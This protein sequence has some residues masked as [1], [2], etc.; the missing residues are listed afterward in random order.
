MSVEPS[1]WEYIIGLSRT[2]C[3]LYSV[4]PY[5][6]ES[7]SGFYVEDLV[8]LHKWASVLNCEKGTDLLDYMDKSRNE[9]IRQF[10]TN[11]NALLMRYNRLKRRPYR[12]KIGRR[13]YTDYLTNLTTGKYYGVRLFCHDIVGGILRLKKVGGMFSTTGTIQV[14]IYNN[15]NEALYT[16]DINTIAGAYV[17]TDLTSLDIELPLHSEYVGN[18]EYYIYYEKGAANPRNNKWFDE[19]KG[20]YSENSTAYSSQTK[21]QFGWGQY[22]KVNGLALSDVSDLSDVVGSSNRYMY[23]LILDVEALCKIGDLWCDD[24]VGFDYEGDNLALAIAEAVRWKAASILINDI[25][26]SNNLNRSVMIDGETL[27]ERMDRWERSYNEALDFIVANIDITK[28]DC[29]ECKDSIEI[30]VGGIKY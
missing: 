13:K 26:L 2:S 17:E 19:H 16:F 12:G 5:H 22:C 3:E 23:G 9:A 24:S 25:L 7:D 14:K 28:T 6:S 29:F 18:L 4:D 8:P 20:M 10:R 30:G 1:C 15:L 21:E 27:Q 11:A